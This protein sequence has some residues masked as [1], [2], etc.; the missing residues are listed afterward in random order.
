MLT[1][2]ETHLG[3]S[4]WQQ[5]MRNMLPPLTFVQTLESSL[6]GEIGIAV[7]ASNA[8]VAGDDSYHDNSG[9][10]LILPPMDPYGP[11][12]RWL[13]IF[14]RGV[15]GCDWTITP[16]SEYVIASPSSGTAGG[17]GT[18]TRVFI[19]VDWSK[20]P[21]APNSSTVN[22]NITSSC[23]R[24]G[25]YAPPLVSLPVT[26]VAV[27][28][29]FIGFIESDKHIAIEA[30]HASRNTTVGG[31]AYQIFT[32]LG[33]TLSGVILVPALAP[34][35]PIGY[36]PVLEYDIFTFTN[37]TKANVTLYLS[38]SLNQM[39]RTRPLRYAA[40]FDSELPKVVQPIANTTGLD[41]AALPAGWE[42]AVADGVWGLT[43][44]NSTT[45]T[46]DLSVIGK[47][48]LKI[49]ALEPGIVVQ[50]IVIDLG[51]VRRSYLGPPESF[52]AGFDEVGSYD[53]TN[54]AGIS[55]ESLSN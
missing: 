40:A 19:S 30:E 3:Y 55:T 44:G 43:S 1:S 25:S 45:T 54:F 23:S 28:S 11:K 12:T 20:A 49:W 13:D 47:H 6:G 2:L 29:G 17:N 15:S 35:Q 24:W 14:G 16:W 51:G 53:G 42:A 22:I 7:E 37:T 10:K 41:G 48:T 32:G 39:G 46:H 18:D 9:N 5:P 34:S 31:V 52:R 21:T 38:T 4:Y 33:R 8:S 26:N 50:K 27:P 36:G